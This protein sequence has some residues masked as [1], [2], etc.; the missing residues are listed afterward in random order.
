MEKL[1]MNK[2]T[3]ITAFLTTIFFFS[4][5]CHRDCINE[6]NYA[7]ELTFEEAIQELY[8]NYGVSEDPHKYK[9]Y[10]QSTPKGTIHTPKWYYLAIDNYRQ[11][12]SKEAACNNGGESLKSFICKIVSDKTF[13]KSRVKLGQEGNTSFNIDDIPSFRFLFKISP[14]YE[15][16]CE[17]DIQSWEIIDEN[18]ASFVNSALIFAKER[19][20]F[21]RIDGHWYLTKF[22]KNCALNPQII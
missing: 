13:F 10:Q 7:E 12:L 5:G 3:I 6:N 21:T 17:V 2:K 18:E 15:H 20:S 22:E 1:I 11:F 14:V 19:F 16:F 4:V 9:S 8:N